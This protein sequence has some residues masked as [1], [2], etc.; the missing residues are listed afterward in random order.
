MRFGVLLGAGA[1]ILG[2]VEIGTGAKVGT[3]SIILADVTP[4]ST[5][6]GVPAVAVGKVREDNPAIE[7]NPKTRLSQRSGEV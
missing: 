7:M 2:R 1:K 5:A 3:G 6:V 4:H